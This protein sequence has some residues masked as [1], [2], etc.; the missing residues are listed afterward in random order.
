M[1]LR[2][3][4][5]LFTSPSL[6][7]IATRGSSSPS[8]TACLSYTPR[9]RLSHARLTQLQYGEAHVPPLG[10]SEPCTHV[11][12]HPPVPGWG[13]GLIQGWIGFCAEF[14]IRKAEIQ[15]HSWFASGLGRCSCTPT[16]QFPGYLLRNTWTSH[17]KPLNPLPYGQYIRV[18]PFYQLLPHVLITCMGKVSR[19]VG[20]GPGPPRILLLSLKRSEAPLRLFPAEGNHTRPQATRGLLPPPRAAESQGGLEK[21]PHRPEPQG[22]GT[23]QPYHRPPSGLSCISIVSAP[24]SCGPSRCC[25]LQVLVFSPCF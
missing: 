15:L 8:S 21:G 9:S 24:G 25:K 2:V 19:P 18:S 23:I 14:P 11:M 20:H 7:L 16:Y 10:A 3:S 12:C 22:L 5:S 6:S 17:P 1:D 4:A 13:S